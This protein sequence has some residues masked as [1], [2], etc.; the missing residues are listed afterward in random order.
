MSDSTTRNLLEEA[1]DA[2]RADKMCKACV[3][4]D[5]VCRRC[6]LHNKNIN[7]AMYGCKDHLTNSQYLDRI[8]E[9][10]LE[11]EKKQMAKRY[12]AMDL[13]T[14]FIQGSMLILEKMDREQKAIFDSIEY[15]TEDDKQR[16]TKK[17]DKRE[18]LRKGYVAMKCAAQDLRNAYNKYVQYY[19]DTLYNDKDGYDYKESD[20]SLVN[21]GYI[22]AIS[23]GILNKVMDS[24]ENLNALMNFVFSLKG[25]DIMNK[26]ECLRYIVNR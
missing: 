2:I 23:A 8:A 24:E 26:Q 17:K 10:Q 22:T 14:Y 20:K 4:S 19:L 16:Y 6:I 1:K 3:F 5:E 12:L 9:E 7:S 25:V 15:P 18:K 11:M 21:A 13:M